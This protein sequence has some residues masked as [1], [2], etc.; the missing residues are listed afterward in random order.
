VEAMLLDTLHQLILLIQ[1]RPTLLIQLRPT[2]L[3][4]VGDILLPEF[5]VA[6]HFRESGRNYIHLKAYRKLIVK[7]DNFLQKNLKKTFKYA[8]FFKKPKFLRQKKFFY[9]MLIIFGNQFF[10]SFPTS[11]LTS[12][13]PEM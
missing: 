13:F 11:I 5:L 2:L 9:K 12:G 6:S 1:L 4:R 8:K 10:T 7:S 3:I